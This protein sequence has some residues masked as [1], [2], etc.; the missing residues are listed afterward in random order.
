MELYVFNFNFERIDIIDVFTKAEFAIN[1]KKHSELDLIVDATEE[2]ISYFIENNDDIILTKST[3]TKHGY[4]PYTVK[5]TDDTQSQIEIYCKSL[6]YLLNRRQIDNQQT[7]TGTVED[8]LR[9]FVNTNAI[10]P[11]NINR[12]IPN[13]VLG[14]L[15]GF[16][17]STTE[18][19][20]NKFLD[21]ALWE[22][23]IKFDIAY[24]ILMDVENQKFI[25]D[26]WQ[27]TDRTIEQSDEESVIFS[28]AFDNVLNQNYVDD[29]SDYRNVAFIISGEN[30]ATKTQLTVNDNIS[31]F[32]RREVFINASDLTG[33]D[34]TPTDAILNEKAN[35]ILASDYERVR[36]F[37][38]DIDYNSQF[39]Y[40][41]D[42]WGGDKVSIRNDE[43]NIIMHTRIITAKETYTKDGFELKIEFGSNVPTLM[44][45]IKKAVS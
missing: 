7:Y 1:Y 23:C 25:L 26:I 27:G 12:I 8:T 38:T 11:T 29:K 2:N 28:K 34:E 40:L 39:V 42:Y 6:S 32:Q 36:S 15:K 9:Y 30:G 18:A 4:I 5:Y 13:L 14:E 10:N 16:T 37:E 43:I 22:I 44:S 20:A 3:D 21:E 35:G 33:D 17:T 31:G 41:V 45:K 24:D 19:F